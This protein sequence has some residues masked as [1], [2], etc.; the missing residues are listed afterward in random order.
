MP[1]SI[2][3]KPLIRCIWANV[4]PARSHCPCV[5]GHKPSLCVAPHRGSVLLNNA[6]ND[7]A[8]LACGSRWEH[9]RPALDEEQVSL[10]T[11]RVR[12]SRSAAL[13]QRALGNVS[14]VRSAEHRTHPRRLQKEV[15]EERGRWGGTRPAPPFPPQ[16]LCS[17]C[18][19]SSCALPARHTR[20]LPLR[21]AGSRTGRAAAPHGPRRAGPGLASRT[22][23][24]GKGNRFAAQTVHVQVTH[25]RYE[26]TN[27]RPPSGV[28]ALI[29][30]FF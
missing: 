29:G 12:L 2:L 14:Q 24:G 9:S 13:R 26:S 22:A 5:P 10:V 23:G 4:I 21:G 25:C 6:T 16:A 1:E 11:L 19:R 7:D 20:W 27:Q 28:S 15:M 3:E 17:G 18:R 8:P 30:I